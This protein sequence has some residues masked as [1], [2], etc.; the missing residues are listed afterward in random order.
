MEEEF[1]IISKQEDDENHRR[2]T[3]KEGET[4]IEQVYETEV[5]Y[6]INHRDYRY[7]DVKKHRIV[8]AKFGGPL[9]VIRN[10]GTGY[11]SY[12]STDPLKKEICF[13]SNMGEIRNRIPLDEKEKIVGMEFLEDELLCLI[14]QSGNYYLIDPNPSAM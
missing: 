13:Y 1:T 8:A 14:L 9:C 12:D 11:I 2:F 4:F 6:K 7:I 3:R 5:V 10:L